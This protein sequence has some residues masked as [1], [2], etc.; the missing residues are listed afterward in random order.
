MFRIALLPAPNVI[1]TERYVSCVRSSSKDDGIFPA[2]Q[3]HHKSA[4]LIAFDRRRLRL[5]P[6]LS[7]SGRAHAA[8]QPL[9]PGRPPPPKPH[10]AGRWR[11]RRR[12]PPPPKFFPAP[13]HFPSAVS[14]FLTLWAPMI[15][16]VVFGSRPRGARRDGA[17]S[18]ETRSN[19]EAPPFSPAALHMRRWRRAALR[20]GKARG[21]PRLAHP[22]LRAYRIEPKN[23]M[24]TVPYPNW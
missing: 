6:L 18:C 19:G 1:T 5:S 14:A 2:A 9:R 22:S 10:E 7:G 8:F 16:M 12:A 21:K 17:S 13:Y 24:Q 3:R 15:A 4:K 23:V 20:L 11:Q